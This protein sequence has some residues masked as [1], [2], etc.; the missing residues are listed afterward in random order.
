MVVPS[1][2]PNLVTFNGGQMTD[3][4]VFSG[5]FDGTE[6]IEIVAPGNEEDGINYSI[7]SAALAAQLVPF[8]AVQVVIAQ[9]QHATALTPYVV[10]ANV[11]RVYVNKTVAEPTYIQ[12]GNASAQIDDVLVKDVAGTADGAGNGIFTTVT[13]DGIANPTITVPYG[14]F[15]FRPVTSLNKWTLGTS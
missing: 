3:L 8:G 11:A 12:F 6:L 15:F 2:I 13:T 14:G 7:T 4:P 10:P 1:A 9:G 5:T